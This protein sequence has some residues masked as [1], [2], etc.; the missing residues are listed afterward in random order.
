MKVHGGRGGRGG[1]GGDDRE[2]CDGMTAE[3]RRRIE[4]GH[5]RKGIFGFMMS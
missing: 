5:N 4:R 1:D 2:R 3:R